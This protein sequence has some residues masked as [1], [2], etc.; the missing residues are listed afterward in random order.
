MGAT[1]KVG[2]N[3]NTKDLL[4]RIVL[5]LVDS[6]DEVQVKSADSEQGT[7]FLVTVAPTD[8]G[9]VIGKGGRNAQALRCLL[10]AFGM[11]LRARYTLDI[12]S[13]TVTENPRK[14]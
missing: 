2:K 4:H 10:S 7:T 11:K 14:L 9:K 1:G 6:P 5:A 13:P 12:I 8:V 3:I